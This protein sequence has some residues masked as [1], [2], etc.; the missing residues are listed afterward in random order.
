VASD[1]LTRS[2][3]S[4]C[5]LLILGKY[6]RKSRRNGNSWKRKETKRR[7]R[8]TLISRRDGTRMYRRQCMYCQLLNCLLLCFSFSKS[9]IGEYLNNHQTR[10]CGI[11]A[12]DLVA[13]ESQT[14]TFL[15]E[16]KKKIPKNMSAG[17]ERL[18]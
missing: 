10:V 6:R 2:S 7:R 9:S 12:M 13:K 18:I 4:T 15:L 5:K 17:C 11:R 3:R 1:I 14:Y 8:C 16:K